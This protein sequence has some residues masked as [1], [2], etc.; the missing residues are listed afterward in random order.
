L[1]LAGIKHGRHGHGENLFAGQTDLDEFEFDFLI[2][3]RLPD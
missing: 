1:F 3:R 2:D